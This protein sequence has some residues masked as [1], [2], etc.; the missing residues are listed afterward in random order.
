MKI[1]KIFPLFLILFFVG[2]FSVPQETIEIKRYSIKPET[3][4]KPSDQA[5][6]LSLRVATFNADAIFRGSRMVYCEREQV[7]D[8]YYY[9]RW[10]A[11]PEHLL[12]DALAVDLFNWGFFGGGVFQTESGVFP[13]HE[14]RGRLT[15]LYANNIRGE[16]QAVMEI[17]LQLFEISPETYEHRLVFQKQYSYSEEREDSNVPSFIAAVN[18]MAGIWIQEVRNDLKQILTE[19]TGGAPGQ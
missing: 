3:N 6:P 1:L 8:Y 15:G 19:K 10:I 18:R 17:R 4:L 7:T 16:Y 5:L 9:H 13:T 2:C 14:L 11:P 12:E